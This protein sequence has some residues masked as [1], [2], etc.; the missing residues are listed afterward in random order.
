MKY[1]FQMLGTGMVI[2][3]RHLLGRWVTVVAVTISF[4]A[5]ATANADTGNIRVAIANEE[6]RPLPAVSI[7]AESRSG[8][9]RNV[10]TDDLGEASIDGLE[11]GLYRISA[12]LK[13]YISV[14]EP[15]LRVVRDKTIPF[16]LQMRTA[17][18]SMD[19]VLVVAKAVRTDAFGAVSS[20]FLNREDLRT[21]VGS[22]ADVLR[23][24][25]GLPGLF[26]TGE[27]ASFTVR[28]RG[29]RDNLILVDGFPYDKVVHFDQSLGEQED[30]NGGGRFSIF[31]P[32][33]IEGAEFSPGGWSA[34]YGGRNGS[35]LK[36]DVARGNPSPSASLRID[37]AGFEAIYDGPSGFHDDT[38]LIFTA[39]RFDFGQ[40]FETIDEEDIGSPVLTDVILKTHTQLN[41][42]NELEFLLLFTPETYERDVDN[43]LASED[44]QERELVDTEQ[45]TGLFGVTWSRLVGDDGRWEN[46]LYF[47][48]S[49]KTSREGEAFP[50][51][52]PMILPP[53]DV[54]VR[55]EIITLDENETEFGWRSDFSNS[56][57]WG[58]FSA[59]LRVAELDL[60]FATTLADDWIRY[61]YDSGDFRPDPDQ[62]YI[63][64]T[65]ANTNAAFS[66]SELQYAAYVEQ[67][68]AVGQWDLR[69]GLRYDYDRFSD[70]SY[71]SPRLSA[72]YRFSP[73]T[74]LSMTAG[75]FYQSPR[76]L[77][78]AADPTN[79]NLANEKTNHV[80]LGVNRRIGKNWDVLVEAYY[81]QL[82][83]LVTEPDAVTGLATNNGEGT[84]YG[85]DVVVN[86]RFAEEW[87]ANAVY[88]YNAA[89]LDDNDGSGEYDAPFNHEHLFS[90]GAK[91]EISERWL[92]GFR[93]KYATGRPRDDFI[94]HEDVL[95]D[96]G[97]PLRFSEES[98]SSGTLRWEDYH[99]LNIRADYRRPLGPV[100][101]IAFLD[102]L[103]VYGSP[104]S[105]ER[106]FN[107]A[108]GELTEDDEGATPL[109]G[110]R[111]EKT[112]R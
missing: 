10:S 1:T 52:E 74:R 43:V 111:F 58:E 2:F 54:P 66:R 28:G 19:E 75:T 71:L 107:S 4:N 22:G 69:T 41:A 76:F 40:F 47:R 29:P 23:A 12:S 95:A 70:D 96:I 18:E 27:F 7:V 86:R 57:R 56:N 60:D 8:D 102:V 98:I 42:R 99:Q 32:T 106:E 65:P 55:E 104:P 93:W 46:R 80:S 11:A 64:L 51:S 88:S 68:F 97:G 101:F 30:I 9:R 103:N 110:I 36:L 79:F 48:D 26:S 59:G 83:D 105:D 16:R 82:R 112:W 77:D 100:D 91:W 31:P 61:Q 84:S 20:S 24:L 44:L 5:I 89:T 17:D 78:R 14:V 67:V 6:G 34:A 94:I 21:A 62:R 15:N 3:R 72:N 109:I 50:D 25:D 13:G 39:R 53:E 108:T 85:L 35:L 90:I 87:S 33:L 73:A 38:S 63:V 37:L 81:Q 49:D 45:D 92:V